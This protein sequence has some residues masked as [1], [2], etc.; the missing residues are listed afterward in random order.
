MKVKIYN[1]A[2]VSKESVQYCLFSLK[3]HM[4]KHYLVG[5][6]SALEII[7]GNRLEGIRLFILPGGRDLSYIQKLQGKG[8][9]CI[10]DYVSGGGNFLGICAGSYYSGR[11]VVFAQSTPFR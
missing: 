8:N 10:Q 11:Y 9:K 5:Y 6:I 1:D 3:L 2:G 7:E 4:P